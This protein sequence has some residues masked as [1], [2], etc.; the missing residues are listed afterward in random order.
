MIHHERQEKKAQVEVLNDEYNRDMV[1]I[2]SKR[3]NDIR[4]KKDTSMPTY[5][6]PLERYMAQHE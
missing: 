1:R 3:A 4:R 5:G 6:E 2:E